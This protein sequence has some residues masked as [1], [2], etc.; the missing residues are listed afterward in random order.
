[1]AVF[2]DGINSF[3]Y[4]LF[5]YKVVCFP[6]RY[7]EF[8]QSLEFIQNAQLLFHFITNAKL[9]EIFTLRKN[10]FSLTNN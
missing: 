2:R 10:S 7:L 3:S 9:G 1:M 5:D 4:F 6:T 8:H